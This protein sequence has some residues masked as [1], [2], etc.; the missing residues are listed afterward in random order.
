MKSIL[1]EASS[2][3]KAIDKAWH[4]AG[5]PEEFTVKVFEIEKKNFLGFVKS[6]SVI[7]IIYDP[8]KAFKGQS[9]KEK[10]LK[11]SSSQHQPEQ[12]YSHKRD[13]Y[14]SYR[15]KKS[16]TK[17]RPYYKNGY[18]EENESSQ[19]QQD[20]GGWQPEML[21]DVSRWLKETTEILK[22]NSRFEHSN[23]QNILKIDFQ[24]PVLPE[25]E[26]EQMLFAS[27]SHLL[28]Q[29]LKKKYKNQGKSLRI[30]ISSSR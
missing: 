13:D 12:S 7:S 25:I 4:A 20:Q 8:R 17:D 21:M 5:M 28:L 2:V 15:Q 10:E 19:A 27:L 24:G 16:I 9:Q 23:Y 14:H 18:S 6:P 11:H 26:Y 1:Q 29:F 30:L 22:V 3:A